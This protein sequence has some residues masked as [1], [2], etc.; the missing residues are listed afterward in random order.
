[1][2]GNDA[3]VLIFSRNAFYQRLHYLALAALGMC[4]VTI[5]FLAYTVYYLIKTP[6]HPIYFA[7]DYVGRLIQIVPVNI[8]NMTAPK[9][10]QWTMKAV[11]A[12]YSFDF[13]NYRSQLQDAQKY[14]TAY[15]WTRYMT[16]LTASNNLLGVIQRKQIVTAHVVD[17]PKLLAGGILSGSYAWKYE[18]PLLVTYAEPPYD[19]QHQFSNALTVNV[20]VQREQVLEGYNGLGILQMIA[21]LA[22]SPNNNQP[23]EISGTSTGG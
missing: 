19:E 2:D 17:Q 11:E 20:I 7:T 15:G 23:Q 1:M 9:I 13:I 4:L 21:T 3:L 10:M 16:A 5:L 22:S 8:P 6:T 14:F 12:A 18:M